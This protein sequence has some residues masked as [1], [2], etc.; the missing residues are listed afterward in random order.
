MCQFHVDKRK[1]FDK[2]GFEFEDYF[3]EEAKHIHNCIEDGLIDE[4]S[5]KIQVTDLGKIFIRNVCMG[6]DYYLRQKNGH[7]RFSRTV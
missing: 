2:F 7:Q 4:D 1:F 3:F 5:K 6:F